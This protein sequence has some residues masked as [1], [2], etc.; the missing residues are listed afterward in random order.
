M[1]WYEETFGVDSA[2]APEPPVSGHSGWSLRRCAQE[3]DSGFLDFY[4]TDAHDKAD[5]AVTSEPIQPSREEPSVEVIGTSTHSTAPLNDS[6]RVTSRQ[7]NVTQSIVTQGISLDA[8]AFIG[9]SA[10][11]RTA[12]GYGTQAD[13]LSSHEVSH[14]RIPPNI[15][16][17][18]AK[19]GLGEDKV[20]SPLRQENG[21]LSGFHHA[22][23]LEARAPVN[24]IPKRLHVHQDDY[25]SG[26]ARSSSTHQIVV[27]AFDLS[28]SK[29]VATKDIP[30]NDTIMDEAHDDQTNK[31]HGKH[32][33]A[34]TGIYFFASQTEG[35]YNMQQPGAGQLV[36]D[37][38]RPWNFDSFHSV[39]YSSPDKSHNPNPE[40]GNPGWTLVQAK[41]NKLGRTGT[42][43]CPNDFNVKLPV[44][45]KNFG[46]DSNFSLS[47]VPHSLESQHVSAHERQ[48][49]LGMA[50]NVPK[51][52]NPITSKF[53]NN[54]VNSDKEQATEF[55]DSFMHGGKNV[56]LGTATQGGFPLSLPCSSAQ[57][58][59]KKDSKN[60][61]GG[62]ETST[63]TTASTSRSEAAVH[64]VSNAPPQSTKRQRRTAP[65]PAPASA[66]A[67][68]LANPPGFAFDVPRPHH[69]IDRWPV[70][71]RGRF[72]PGQKV[73]LKV[74]DVSAP[75]YS[76]E[77]NSQY[78]IFFNANGNVMIPDAGHGHGHGN[79]NM[80]GGTSSLLVTSYYPPFALPPQ[81]INPYSLINLTNSGIPA[82][83]GNI[84]PSYPPNLDPKSEI[85]K[86]E[87]VIPAPANAANANANH[88]KRRAR[89]AAAASSTAGVDENGEGSAVGR[90]IKR[91]RVSR[92]KNTPAK[93]KKTPAK[94]RKK[95]VPGPNPGPGPGSGSGPGSG[96]RPKPEP[97]PGPKPG[98]GLGPGM[99]GGGMSGTGMSGGGM[100]M[101]GEG[102][103]GGYRGYGG[104]QD[105]AAVTAAPVMVG[106]LVYL[107]QDPAALGLTVGSNLRD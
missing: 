36:N 107:P 26:M 54:G 50:S 2:V 38:N 74:L 30:P 89:G 77:Y 66:P 71:R 70:S 23:V 96:P 13:G 37:E 46:G 104:Y 3:A 40:H 75:V 7:D 62:G 56:M 18:D 31:S 98:P 95:S 34:R 32:A 90:K 88:R 106:G 22:N 93:P 11:A 101:G 85:P 59:E 1:N 48:R 67:P 45:N 60:T 82:G 81:D 15:E 69:I 55:E 21:T 9:T 4:Y 84:A 73:P 103:G 35:T 79:M 10:P 43:H 102:Y 78:Q 76:Q 42:M 41:P 86:P 94:P 19:N 6:S 12:S 65:A 68:V 5:N 25:A 47:Y 16:H 52:S 64:G 33:P 100:S 92:A 39:L 44:R 80:N 97:G 49:N 20:V 63:S 83:N 17:V 24:G 87:D 91:A 27:S 29:V 99:S 105:G 58:E 57:I 53:G 51:D 14:L 61:T 28:T 72:V 8:T